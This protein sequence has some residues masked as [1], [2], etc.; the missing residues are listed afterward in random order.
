[1]LVLLLASGAIIFSR[2]GG[3]APEPATTP[4]VALPAAGGAY[5]EGVLGLPASFNPLLATSQSEKDLRGLLF[6]GLTRVDGSGMAQP[7]LASDWSVSDD[8]LTYTFE[9]RQ[10]VTWHDGQPVTARDVL[11]TISLVQDPDFPGQPALARFWRGVLVSAPDDHTVVFSLLEPFAAFPTY[12]ALPIVPQHLLGGSLA[13]DLAQHPFSDAPVGTGPFRFEAFDPDEQMVRLTANDAYFEGRPHLDEVHLRYFADAE[14]VLAAMRDG[15]VQGTGSIAADQLLRPGALPQGAVVYASPMS[16]L[17]ALF[18]NLRTPE[19]ANVEVRR[20]LDLAIDRERILRGPLDDRAELGFGPVPIT[21]W[22]YGPPTPVYDPEEAKRLL[23][24]AGWDEI[25]DDGVRQRGGAR[26]SFSL[27]VND[28][29]PERVAV[30]HEIVAQ[31]QEVGVQVTVQA[32]PPADVAHALA[33]R[34]YSA[35]LFGWHSP[36][37][38]PDCYQ[39]WHSSFSD[40]GLNFTGLRDQEIDR[41]LSDARRESDPGT[42][43]AMYHEFQQRFADQVPAI[44]LYYPRYYFTVASVIKG[45]EPRAVVE[46]SDRMKYLPQWFTETADPEATATP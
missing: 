29:D 13:R 30:A 21:S 31:L 1:M 12:A 5:S 16:S 18:F 19:F 44:V 32:I 26:L 22:A 39:L 20:A 7:D 40:D 11:F 10:D 17:T 25:G 23:D 24:Q 43:A 38:D 28:D 35:A 14:S 46:P 3:E 33:T 4:L 34:Q 36:T 9:L 6:N 2:R 15:T 8:G 45:V 37:G 41:L 42:R 27:L